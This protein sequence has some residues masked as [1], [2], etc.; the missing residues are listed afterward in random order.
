M[1]GVS[2]RTKHYGG[3][4][5]GTKQ[6]IWHATQTKNKT[7]GNLRLFHHPKNHEKR[8]EFVSVNTPTVAGPTET[9]KML[10]RVRKDQQQEGVP[11]F[12]NKSVFSFLLIKLFLLCLLIL[13]HVVCV[14]TFYHYKLIRTSV[15]LT[16]RSCKVL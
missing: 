5:S 8:A 11:L 12:K 1:G 4:L 9:V 7:D 13:I 15:F 10:M 14:S 16:R 3:F 2:K 6:T